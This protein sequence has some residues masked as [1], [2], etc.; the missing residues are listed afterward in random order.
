ML[1][2]RLLLDL[3][4]QHAAELRQRHARGHKKLLLAQ[5]RQPG[6]L[7]K[8]GHAFAHEG[9]SRRVPLHNPVTT[10]LSA[11]RTAS[12]ARTRTARARAPPVEAVEGR[13]ARAP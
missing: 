10:L 6:P 8:H 5:N 11:S 12:R 3:A 13:A 7:Q 2:L 1:R 4:L 9:D